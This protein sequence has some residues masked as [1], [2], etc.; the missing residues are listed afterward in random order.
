M[1]LLLG[2]GEDGGDNE[3]D[4]KGQS[5]DPPPVSRGPRS[6]L[7][8][9]IIVDGLMEKTLKVVD[10]SRFYRGYLRNAFYVSVVALVSVGVFGGAVVVA[11]FHLTL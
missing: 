6:G 3:P 9:E 7:T 10:G 11:V 2:T 8:V 4:D 5:N 1:L